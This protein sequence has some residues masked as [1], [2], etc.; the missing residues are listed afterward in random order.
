MNKCFLI[1]GIKKGVAAL[2]MGLAVVSVVPSIP[3]AKFINDAVS[4]DVFA[5]SNS[6]GTFDKLT[7]GKNSDDKDWV[8]VKTEKGGKGTVRYQQGDGT[9]RV[10]ANLSGYKYKAGDLLS[11]KVEGL[12]ITD[13]E[14]SIGYSLSSGCHVKT[15]Q[16]VSQHVGYI[17]F[18]L[19]E[20]SDNILKET[21]PKFVR[22]L[23]KFKKPNKDTEFT[24]GG[25]EIH[26]SG[27]LPS[28][29]DGSIPEYDPYAAPKGIAVTYYDG[30][31]SRGFAW[32]TDDHIDSSALYIIEK[33]GGLK[34][35]AVDWSKAIK[36]KASKVKRTD[37]DGKAWHVFKAHVENLK[38]GATYYYRVGNS[39]GGYSEIGTVNIEKK[40]DEIDGLTFVHLTDCQESTK[41]NYSRWANVLE[42]AYERY[43]ETK[44]VAFTGDLTN[45][46]HDYLDMNQWIWGLDEPGD[47]LR[48]SIISP[49]SGNHDKF[50]YSFTDRFDFNYA[51]YV[52]DSNKDLESGGCYYY[53]YGK[54]ILFVNLNTN[55]SPWE[56]FDKQ[57]EWLISVLEKYKNYKWKVVQIHKGIM[58]TGDHTN[59]GDV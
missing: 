37:N 28:W 41:K 22:V 30:I 55:E 42:N 45:D 27:T 15:K 51:D 38:A 6:L 29:D 19:P 59:N 33:T 10:R 14:I 17:T 8:L 23:G 2:S 26:K 43:P 31:Y 1:G 53:T 16:V 13:D 57:Q 56:E 4:I 18:R 48:N 21:D 47:I 58:S 20:D 24:F 40:E 46:S 25:F 35:E 12:D 3:S 9:Y 7:V 49:S 36:V 34:K 52:K 32:S 54:D 50:K 5:A 11:I 44:F 39:T